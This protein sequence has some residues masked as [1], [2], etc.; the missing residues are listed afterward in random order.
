MTNSRITDVELL[1][2]RY[3]V[4]VRRF[5][6]RRGSGGAGRHPGGEGLVR[7]LEFLA[8]LTV[9]V[10]SE[11]RTRAPFGLAGGQPG[12]PGAYFLNDAALPGKCS[13][14][15]ASGDVLRI[16]TPGGGGFGPPPMAGKAQP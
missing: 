14:R 15:V 5:A 4:R 3:P 13:V 10:I 9:S 6:L 11:R 8:P 2:A 7:E 1:E 16:E 12:A